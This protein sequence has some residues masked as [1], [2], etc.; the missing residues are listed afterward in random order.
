MVSFFGLLTSYHR[1]C[2]LKQQKFI[3]MNWRLGVQT[4]CVS[5]DTLPLKPLGK[6][7]SSSSFRILTT[8]LG[9]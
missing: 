2:D 7:P 6:Y 8:F 5:S 3:L 9:L 4:Q 1:L